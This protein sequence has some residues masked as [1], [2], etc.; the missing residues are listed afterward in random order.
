VLVDAGVISPAQARTH[1][2]RHVVTNYVGVKALDERPTFHAVTLVPGDR[3]LLATD[4]LTGSLDDD[5]VS[6]I[7]GDAESAQGA[8]DELVLAALKH[9]SKDNIACIVVNVLRKL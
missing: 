9:G 5:S 6:R 2:Y 1:K 3:L 8:A 4:G 7:I